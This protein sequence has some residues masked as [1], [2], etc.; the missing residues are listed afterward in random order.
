MDPLDHH[1][2]F[3]TEMSQLVEMG[4]KEIKIDKDSMICGC[5]K[6]CG[7]TDE[8]GGTSES[9]FLLMKGMATLQGCRGPSENIFLFLRMLHFSL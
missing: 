8:Q 7:A 4:T 1:S 5:A 2:S 9:G 3:S 6:T